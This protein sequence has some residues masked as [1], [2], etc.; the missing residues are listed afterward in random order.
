M[1]K[2]SQIITFCVTGLLVF[3]I[4]IGGPISCMEQAQHE[5]TQRVQTACSGN[6]N[7]DAARSAACVLALKDAERASMN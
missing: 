7:I 1:Q 3:A 2:T 6:L 4:L 5:A